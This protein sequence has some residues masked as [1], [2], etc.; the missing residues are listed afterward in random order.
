MVPYAPIT[1]THVAEGS[2]S[3]RDLCAAAVTVG[4]NA[5]ANILLQPL[6]G[7]AA[8]TQF[9]RDIGD[10][11]TRLDRAKCSQFRRGNS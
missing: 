5:A 3:V 6:G 2:M 4:D 1:S 10:P 7:P 9:M 11:D 8:L